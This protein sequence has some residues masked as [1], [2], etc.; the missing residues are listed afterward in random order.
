MIDFHSNNHVRLRQ[1]KC[2]RLSSISPKFYTHPISPCKLHAAAAVFSHSLTQSLME[3]SLSWEAANSAATQELPSILWNP[4]VHYCVHWS[5]S[6][7]RSIQYMS[8]YSISLRFILILSTHLRL[9][10]PSG[11]FT[12]GFPTHILYAFLFSPVRA[13][14]PAYLILLD[15]IILFILWEEYKLWN[16]S[17][18]SFIQPPATISLFGPNILLSGRCIFHR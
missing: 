4:K 8:S 6:W 16:S 14:C 12:S 15:L 10:L 18:C 1:L 11:L 9:G 17:I 13:A 2:L 7:A 5:L 3:Q